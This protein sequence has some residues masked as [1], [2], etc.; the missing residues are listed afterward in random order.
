MLRSTHF[1]SLEPDEGPYIS[2]V[3]GFDPHP[4]RHLPFFCRVE[5][6]YQEEPP[7]FINE[8]RSLFALFAIVEHHFRTK[9]KR[10][11][12]WPDLGE[13]DT[14]EI[15]R[16][17]ILLRQATGL[18]RSEPMGHRAEFLKEVA[19]I[20]GEDAPP[21]RYVQAAKASY[22]EDHPMVLAA[23]YDAWR[24]G[25]YRDA[26][27]HLIRHLGFK[28]S[29][30]ST[31]PAAPWRVPTHPRLRRPRRPRGAHRR[32][33][34]ARRRRPRSALVAALATRRR[35]AR[36]RRG[37]VSHAGHDCKTP[38]FLA[39]F[40]ALPRAAQQPRHQPARAS[41]SD[42]VRRPTPP[43]PANDA[44][45]K[46]STPRSEIF[47]AKLHW[48]QPAVPAGSSCQECSGTKS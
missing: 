6:S 45:N 15:I 28:P 26:K 20:F 17:H 10:P 8:V 23:A 31:G 11:M 34:A 19:A 48:A 42:D 12:V 46:R 30:P 13:E 41:A 44:L 14:V 27:M 24:L 39:S 33:G 18:D 37:A 1:T 29:A 21:A 22:G 43:D 5:V 32:A 16:N 36:S 4:E 9:E 3:W 2:F 35:H 47:L 25:D 7:V 40:K 38:I